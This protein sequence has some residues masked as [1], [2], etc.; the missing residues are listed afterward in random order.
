[1]NRRFLIGGVLVAVLALAA[2]GLYAIQF[3]T[4]Q[5]ASSSGST[6]TTLSTPSASPAVGGSLAGKWV[7]ASGSSAGYRATEQFVGQAGPN[8]AIADS[9]A[10]S[11]GMVIANQ[12]GALVAQQLKVTVDLTQL[13]SSDPGAIHGSF[14]RDRFV[15]PMVLNTGQFPNATYQVDSIST[16]ATAAA[17]GQQTLAT[18]GKLTVHGVARDVDIPM[19]SQVSGDKIEVVGSVGVDMTDYGIQAPSVGFTSVQPKVTIAFHLFFARG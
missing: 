12:G 8:Q 18:H 14:Q 16:P 11:G 15:G 1:L 9:K 6:P 2:L 13:Q 7:V 3:F 10:V 19:T 17:G 4:P 5:K